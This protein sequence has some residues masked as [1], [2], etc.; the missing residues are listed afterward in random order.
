[1]EELIRKFKTPCCKT[2]WYRNSK[3]NFRCKKCDKDVTLEMFFLHK[4][5]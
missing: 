5:I 2:E 1:M 4:D 3:L